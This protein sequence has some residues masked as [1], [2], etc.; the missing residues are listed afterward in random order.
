[1]GVL[2]GFLTW[3]FYVLCVPFS[4]NAIIT[5]SI[6]NLFTSNAARY[7]KL[8]PWVTALVLNIVICIFVPYAY[9]LSATT[10]LLYRILSNPWPYWV[11]FLTSALGGI[12]SVTIAQ[13]SERFFIL[14]GIA[15]VF[16]FAVGVVTF[17]YLSYLELVIFFCASTC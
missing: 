2:L 13:D 17:F 16:L 3:S 9:L 11:I 8:I 1:M 5:T 7:A 6:L 4:N 12:Y 14:H 15:R 10:F